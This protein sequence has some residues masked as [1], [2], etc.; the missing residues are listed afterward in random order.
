MAVSESSR[1]EG[2]RERVDG[3]PHIGHTALPH[4]PPSPLKFGAPIGS[5][6]PAGSSINSGPNSGAPTTDIF[7]SKTPAGENR[8]LFQTR[9]ELKRAREVG[10]RNDEREVREA[11]EAHAKFLAQSKIT[12]DATERKRKSRAQAR[13]AK[14][15]A[16][17]EHII[18]SLF[19]LRQ[20]SPREGCYNTVHREIEQRG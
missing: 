11:R 4:R 6:H 14:I 7:N 8:E 9:R 19:M 20:I 12:N 3:F 13:E 18:L 10:I 2:S 17:W 15:G 1:A 5:P 16:G